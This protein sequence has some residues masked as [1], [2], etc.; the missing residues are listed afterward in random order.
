MSIYA[1]HVF[2]KT[3]NGMMSYDIFSRLVKDRIIMVNGEVT[4]DM[5]AVVISELLFLSAQDPAKEISIY[6]N[7]PG[8]SVVD[9]M[10]IYDTMQAVP[11]DIRTIGTGMCA[12]MGSVLLAGGTKGKRCLLPHSEVMIHQV[13]SGSRGKVTD[14]EIAMEQAKK[15]NEM[16]TNLLAERCGR[17]Y[18]ELK[19]DMRDDNYMTA[20]EALKY[21]IADE[22]IY[23][24]GKKGKTLSDII[25]E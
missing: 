13:S 24:I 25:N 20:T 4:D 8:G 15:S 7:S 22:I 6:I 17:T 10:A 19:R 11:C 2:E 14:M 21:G 9:G 12:S 3:P 23:E 16:L 1:P 5:A 18:E